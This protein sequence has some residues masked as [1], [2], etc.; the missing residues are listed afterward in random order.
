M[1]ACLPSD[2]T[3]CTLLSLLS[4]PK[5][6]SVDVERV[7]PFW[8]RSN[9]IGRIFCKI[10]FMGNYLCGIMTTYLPKFDF[11]RR[12]SV[13]KT[14]GSEPKTG[15]PFNSSYSQFFFHKFIFNYYALLLLF[16]FKGQIYVRIWGKWNWFELILFQ[17]RRTSLR[18]LHTPWW[19]TNLLRNLLRNLLGTITGKQT[20]TRTYKLLYTMKL[21]HT[22]I[23]H[24]LPRLC[25]YIKIS[26]NNI[27][28]QLA[29]IWYSKS[30]FSLLD[31]WISSFYK[32]CNSYG[33]QKSSS[34]LYAD[35]GMAKVYETVTIT[36]DVKRIMIEDKLFIVSAENIKVPE[37][38]FWSFCMFKF[39]RS[40]KLAFKIRRDN[41][42]DC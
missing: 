20:T 33:V 25:L 3:N 40:T 29:K 6:T 23:I 9:T 19:T 5:C 27:M 30:A 10:I 31:C 21:L 13:S 37:A 39:M 42:A 32:V 7:F 14:G 2:E 41:F 8:T 4:D 34:F 35:A 24:F 26:I 22:Q 15:S 38:K 16:L 17:L 28:I 18:T 11:N 12:N 36:N 1:A